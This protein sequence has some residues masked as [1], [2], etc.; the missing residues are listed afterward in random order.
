MTNISVGRLIEPK[1]WS[2]LY[3]EHLWKPLDKLLTY[4]RGQDTINSCYGE[5]FPY[6][7]K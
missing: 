6:A 1:S 2:V 3:G 5:Y 4:Y 7:S